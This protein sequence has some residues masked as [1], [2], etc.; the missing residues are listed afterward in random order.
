M[1]T[2][3]PHEA[4][5]ND[6][7]TVIGHDRLNLV[8]YWRV[9]PN[10]GMSRNLHRMCIRN[11]IGLHWRCGCC[12][13][14]VESML[15]RVHG[16]RQLRR[17]LRDWVTLRGGGDAVAGWEA[18]LNVIIIVATCYCIL[19]FFFFLA[20]LAQS[21][22]CICRACQIS[23]VSRSAAYFAIHGVLH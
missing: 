19:C 4:H 22:R 20:C 21:R 18:F 2:A 16:R 5:A 14:W 1:R 23:R 3:P 13:G 15:F 7:S 10:A 6:A 11:V 12:H 9:L 8:W 17:V